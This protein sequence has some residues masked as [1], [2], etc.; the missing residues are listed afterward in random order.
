MGLIGDLVKEMRHAAG[1]VLAGR[2]MQRRI[3]HARAA[4]E[5]LPA[6][7]LARPQ[8]SSLSV[9]VPCYNHKQFLDT[10]AGSIASQTRAP[11]EVIFIDDNSPDGT[12]HVLEKFA[13]QNRFGRHTGIKI[14]RNGHNIGQAASLNTGIEAS[15]GDLI[16]IMNDDDCLFHDAVELALKMFERYQDIHMLGAQCIPFGSDR[17]LALYHQELLAVWPVDEIPVKFFLPDDTPSYRKLNDLNITHSGCTFYKKSWRIAGG[18]RAERKDRLVPFSDRDFQ[19][20]FNMYFPVGI[21]DIPIS[22]WRH[23]SSVDAGI[24]S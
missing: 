14:I 19:L 18:Y 9:V 11:L 20:R 22:F 5:R 4:L 13:R 10:M 3:A 2:R 21:M 7:E 16:M 15:T 1:T 23:N 24:N 6:H 17:E 12:Q 8:G